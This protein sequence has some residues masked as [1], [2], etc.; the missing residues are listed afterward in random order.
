MEAIDNAQEPRPVRL[1]LL[2]LLP[3]LIILGLLV[4]FVLPRIESVES[5]IDMMRHLAPWAIAMALIFETLS[6]IANGALLQSVVTLGGGHI[7]LMRAIAV[8]LGAGSVALVAAGSLGFG[9]AIY[10][11]T[12]ETVPRETAMLASWLPSVFDSLTLVVF[13]LI[14]AVELLLKHQLSKTTEIALAIV[15]T[16]L[17]GAVATVIAL[18]VRE[19][20]MNAVVLRATRLIRRIKPSADESLLVDVA[21]HA[22]QAW[23]TMRNGG[24]FR[25]AISSLLFLTFDL[26]CLRYALLAAG[27]HPYI[28]T[29]LAAYGVPLLLGRSSFLPGGIAVTEVAMAA[30]LGGLGVPGN[31]AVVAVLTYRLISFWLPAAVGIPIAIALETARRR[32]ATA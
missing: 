16:A 3:V 1:Q 12:R 2:R 6:Y 20:W 30:L 23:S 28:S 4:H 13:A 22:S 29:V 9:A 25:P 15:I 31:A 5:S 26:L 24:F 11:W 8:E 18:L 19:D 10:R 21:E 17:G 7:R 14:G 32:Q 27:Q